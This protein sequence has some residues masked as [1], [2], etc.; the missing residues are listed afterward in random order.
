[1]AKSTIE[2]RYNLAVDSYIAIQLYIMDD[3][4]SYPEFNGIKKRMSFFGG[5]F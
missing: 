4:L 5:S 1:M 2:D 3:K